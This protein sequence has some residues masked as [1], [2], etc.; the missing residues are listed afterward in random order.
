MPG[1]KVLGVGYG[2]GKRDIGR[3]NA[4]RA[5]LGEPN[6]NKETE[7]GHSVSLEANI[8]DMTAEA[9][10]YAMER[11]LN[12]GALDVYFTP[13]YMKKNRPAT[14]LSVLARPDG[15]AS[16]VNIIFKETTTLGVREA[17]LSRTIL[18]RETVTVEL[19][20]GSP[21]RIKI[22]GR[23]GAVPGFI[24][25]AAHRVSPEYDDCREYAIRTGLPLAE[26]YRRVHEAYSKARNCEKTI[27][28]ANK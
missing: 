4:L 16:L 27:E 26:V 2:F 11:L 28:N 12:A 21:I 25:G 6:L 10:G 5:L 7:T 20:P 14:M 3:L 9:L 8:D 22:A 15:A 18:N 24:A 19:E 23:D 17:R 1:L 13:I